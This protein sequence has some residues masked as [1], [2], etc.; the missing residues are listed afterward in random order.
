MS[1]RSIYAFL[2]FLGLCT[3]CR[4][5]GADDMVPAVQLIKDDPVL[6]L[7]AHCAELNA[8]REH[9]APRVKVQHCLIS[10]QGAPRIDQTRSQEAAEKLTGQLLKRIEGGDAD[11][12]AVVAQNT[13]D[14]HPGIYEMTR[15][16]R[17][18]MVPAFGDIGWRLQVGEVGVAAYNQQKS[19]YGWHIIKRLE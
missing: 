11:F 2:L 10:F 5:D 8:R 7:R 19:P 16:S 15:A 17:G 1:T 9:N 3:G 14:S 12:D 4:D 6:A 13:D 18:T